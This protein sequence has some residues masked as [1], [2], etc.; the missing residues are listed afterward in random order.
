MDADQLWYR[1]AY[2]S[3]S[4]Y[5]YEVTCEASSDV[6]AVRLADERLEYVERIAISD[7]L[8]DDGISVRRPP[9]Q[10]EIERVHLD[11]TTRG[12]GVVITAPDGSVVRK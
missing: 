11:E 2:V 1:V 7:Q 8:R 5:K 9:A 4:G 10:L 12:L 6:E 3:P